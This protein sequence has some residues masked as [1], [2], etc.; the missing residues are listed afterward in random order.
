MLR[1]RRDARD[2]DTAGLRKLDI[3]MLPKK[4]RRLLM[5]TVFKLLLSLKDTPEIVSSGSRDIPSRLIVFHL[6]MREG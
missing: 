4:R 6:P 1:V 3:R 5:Y 2:C